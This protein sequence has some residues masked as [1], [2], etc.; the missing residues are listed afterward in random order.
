MKQNN[1]SPPVILAAIPAK[2]FYIL[3]L[4]VPSTKPAGKKIGLWGTVLV[5]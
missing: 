5:P 1:H 2:A 3:T 4:E